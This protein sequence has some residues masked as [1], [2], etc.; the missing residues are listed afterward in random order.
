MPLLSRPRR[1]AVVW[2][3]GGGLGHVARLVPL[4][5]ALR[6][7]GHDISVI[8]R[9]PRRVY[10][11]LDENVRD[12]SKL[13]FYRTPTLPPRKQRTSNARPICMTFADVLVEDGFGSH[14]SLLRY[15]TDWHGLLAHVAPDLVVSDFAPGA[16]IVVRGAIP[17]VVVGNGYTVPPP[18]LVPLLDHPLPQNAERNH[19]HLRSAFTE[20]ARK[21]GTAGVESVGH[22]MRGDA[23]FPLTSPLF[24]PYHGR[25]PEKVLTPYTLPEVGNPPPFER[26]AAA[27]VFLYLP[28]SHPHL[29]IVLGA[30]AAEKC[31]TL[32][33]IPGFDPAQVRLSPDNNIHILDRPASLADILPRMRLLVH[34]GGLGLAHAGLVAGNVQI[35]LP[36][37]LEQELTAMSLARHGAATT[38]RSA[39]PMGM[40]GMSQTVRRSLLSEARA[41][42]ARSLA[43]TSPAEGRESLELVLGTIQEFL[44]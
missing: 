21:I 37:C 34:S 40:E 29:S 1:I 7:A 6:E 27:S 15:L 30:L 5:H 38:C 18:G 9:N 26:R 20:A 31:D 43:T 13:T 14:E 36:T 12:C 3:L 44:G 10:E 32:A 33:F 16:N 2:E 42:R 41:N 28:A 8:A 4:I 35:V 25:R 19:D 11:T 23:N 39:E 17:L 22:L 24:D